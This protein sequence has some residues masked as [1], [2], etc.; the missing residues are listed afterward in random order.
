MHSNITFA[1]HRAQTVNEHTR[2]TVVPGLGGEERA[3]RGP[4][5]ANGGA[6]RDA[7]AGS[8]GI[9][10]SEAREPGSSRVGAAPSGIA[11]AGA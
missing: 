7:S 11:R 2:D 10:W 1:P 8:S 4:S 6:L 5:Y 3:S 9:D